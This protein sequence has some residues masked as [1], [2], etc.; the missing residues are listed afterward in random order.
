M[1]LEWNVFEYD[2]NDNKIVTHNVFKHSR[3]MNDLIKIRKIHN[4]DSEMFAKEVKKSLAYYYWSKC[5]HEIVVTSFPPYVHSKE[6]TR[7]IEQRDECVKKYGNFV[8][9]SVRLETGDKIDVY[10]QIMM[11]WDRFIEYL[12]NNKKLIK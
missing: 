10:G 2:F 8:R 3:L 11:N 1:N 12:W 6:I 7:L 9:E 5:E 4:D